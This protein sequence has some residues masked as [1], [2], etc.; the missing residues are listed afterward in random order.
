MHW[1]IPKE[2][3]IIVFYLIIAKR[4]FSNVNSATLVPIL[5]YVIILKYFENKKLY[6]QRLNSR[7]FFHACSSLIS[8]LHA[9]THNGGILFK[10]LLYFRN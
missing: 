9:C 7:P 8:K 2:E 3:Q 10:R 5:D 6:R 1:T 4:A